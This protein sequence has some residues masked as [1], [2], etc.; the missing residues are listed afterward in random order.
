[1]SST[2]MSS[3]P[4]RSAASCKTYRMVS[5]LEGAKRARYK[6]KGLLAMDSEGVMGKLLKR[7]AL[8]KNSPA[9]QLTTAMN[10]M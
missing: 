3:K 9:Q 6:D 7:K 2:F 1:M 8:S 10:L 4:R 5:W